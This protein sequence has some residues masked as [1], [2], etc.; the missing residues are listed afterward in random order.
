VSI[1]SAIDWISGTSLNHFI[2]VN[3]W[4]IATMQSVHIVAISVVISSVFLLDLRLAGFLGREQSVR[5][6]AL[7]FHP[8]IWGALVVLL[9]TG[10]FLVFGE[11]GREI[12]NP[13]FWTKMAS[14]VLAVLFTMPVRFILEEGN[15]SSLPA[16]KRMTVRVCALVSLLLWIFVIICGRWI[17]YY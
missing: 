6:M 4:T 1:D 9:L 13:V 7:R 10:L 8:W 17:A 16:G 2:A 14:I 11:P 5:G 3:N 15:F 12:G